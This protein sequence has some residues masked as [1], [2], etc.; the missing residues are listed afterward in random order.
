MLEGFQQDIDGREKHHLLG[1]MDKEEEEEENQIKGFR[2]MIWNWD[3]RGEDWSNIVGPAAAAVWERQRFAL[4]H[5]HHFAKVRKILYYSNEAHPMHEW[6]E[7]WKFEYL[8]Y[9]GMFKLRS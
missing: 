9:Y 4:P 6:L 5:F 1:L 7:G 8:W 2:E 3:Q